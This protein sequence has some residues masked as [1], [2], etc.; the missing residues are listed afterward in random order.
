L[1]T[2]S[3]PA[4]GSFQ[5]HL[6]KKSFILHVKGSKWLAKNVRVDASNGDVTGVTVTLLPGDV[7]GN[8][9]VNVG[10]L[11]DLADAFFTSEGDPFWNPQAD[12]NCDNS[13]DI[14]DLAL[15]SDSFFM[16]GDL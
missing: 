13:V 15:L 3:L 10:D 11:S 12:L 6:P 8:N 9:Q 2:V 14:A 1:K 4:D 5:F 7:T 16:D